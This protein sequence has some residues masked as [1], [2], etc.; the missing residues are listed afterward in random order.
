VRRKQAVMP[1][2]K[3]IAHRQHALSSYIFVRICSIMVVHR[4]DARR[5]AHSA[6]WSF[7][8][9]SGMAAVGHKEAHLSSRL[10]S[11]VALLSEG[12]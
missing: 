4:L 8:G 7:H 1:E 3:A 12:E 9:E 6:G 11:A 5:T 10:V 2:K